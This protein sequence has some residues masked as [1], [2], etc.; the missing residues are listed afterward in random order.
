VVIEVGGDEILHLPNAAE[1][2]KAANVRRAA[3][4]VDIRQK[5]KGA[6]FGFT[7]QNV[8]FDSA[9]AKLTRKLR[10]TAFRHLLHMEVGFYD[11]DNHPLGALT[12]RLASDA[13]DV[14][15]MV[16]LGWGETAQFFVYYVSFLTL[17]SGQLSSV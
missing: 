3:E 14:S 9:G 10:S 15:L 13:A 4:K 2:T 16:G 12:S 6:L 5:K 1:M 7:M 11:E 17:N 8:C